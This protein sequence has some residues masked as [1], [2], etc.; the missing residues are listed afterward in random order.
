MSE[1]SAKLQ[2]IEE[3][4]DVACV[5]IMDSRL[6]KKIQQRADQRDISVEDVCH[7]LLSAAIAR[8]DELSQ[9]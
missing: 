3:V 9:F 5:R 4:L 1:K 6:R 8:D 2:Y 7:E